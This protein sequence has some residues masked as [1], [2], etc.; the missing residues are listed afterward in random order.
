M[1]PLLAF[2]LLLAAARSPAQQM[3]ITFDDLPAHG[4]K[5]AGLTRVDIASSILATLKREN[6]PPV[7]GFINGISTQQNPAREDDVLKAWRA[8]G[9]P[10]GNH[11]WA[12]KDLESES[13]EEFEADALQDE[14]LLQKY[15]AGQDWHWFRYP[16]LHEGENLD[17]YRAIHTWLAAHNY[18]VAEVSMDFED[19][20]WNA[21]YAR[22]VARNDTASIQKLHDS[23][24][25]T[26]DQYMTL[27]RQVSKMVYG[28]EIRYILLLHIGAFDAHM[29]PE[30]IALYRS[31]GFS[32]ISLPEAAKDPAYSTE[33]D[34]NIAQKGGGAIPEL[35]MTRLKLKFPPN[36]K[37]Y[38]ELEDTC[39]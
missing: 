8:A 21:P 19:Y 18:K 3:A 10:L 20:L 22:C 30:L 24:L 37:P 34:P 29:L 31:H 39:K 32:F 15:M 6:M 4:Q 28:R 13:P 36:S 2:I 7:Y 12:H 9:Q 33:Q 26:A 14:T 11:T 1:K 16:Y 27:F 38:K 5:P 25:A 23:Y 17:K 35:M